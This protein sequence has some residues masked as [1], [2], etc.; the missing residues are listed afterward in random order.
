MPHM[1]SSLFSARFH[2]FQ[3]IVIPVPYHNKIPEFVRNMIDFMYY[4]AK[5]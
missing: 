5:L 1:A 2:D 3:S 4:K